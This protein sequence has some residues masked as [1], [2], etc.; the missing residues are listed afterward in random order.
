[1]NELEDWWEGELVQDEEFTHHL[2][3][4][5]HNLRLIAVLFNDNFS[6]IVFTM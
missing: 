2:L 1:M 3:V 4:E 5:L 6:E